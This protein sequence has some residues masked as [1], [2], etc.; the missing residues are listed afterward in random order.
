MVEVRSIG[1]VD[2]CPHCSVAT[3]LFLISWKDQT[4]STLDSRQFWAF[5][6]CMRCGKGVCIGSHRNYDLNYNDPAEIYPMPKRAHEDIPQTARTFLQQAYDTLHSPDAASVMAGSA[7]DATLKELGYTNGSVYSRIDA[8]LSD[9]IITKGMA[10][11][12]HAVRLGANRPRHADLEA[13]HTTSTEAQNSVEFAEALANFLF[14]LSAK[15]TRGIS[16]AEAS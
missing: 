2:R 14:V 3:P 7:V 11:W 15:I 16:A 6:S 5:G 12:A 13:P 8:A 10:D 9:N 1:G 4:P